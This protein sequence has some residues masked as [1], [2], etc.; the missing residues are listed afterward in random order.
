MG[1]QGAVVSRLD[2]ATHGHVA[3]GQRQAPA[4]S[5][6]GRLGEGAPAVDPGPGQRSF[7]SDGVI[8]RGHVVA[9]DCQLLIVGA[10]ERLD[11]V[12]GGQKIGVGQRPDAA[13]GAALGLD[14][15]LAGVG[16]ERLRARAVRDLAQLDGQE[17]IDNARASG[18]AQDKQ[19]L[20]ILGVGGAG[21][22]RGAQGGAGRG[23]GR[24]QASKTAQGVSTGDGR[25]V[26]RNSPRSR[27]TRWSSRR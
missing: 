11:R 16:I 14:Q 5:L 27:E 17:T 1:H 18:R 9:D 3:V 8:D 23:Q 25:M 19:E 10:Q 7:L 22:I 24:A 13:N 6:G 26:H 2:I 20:A 15:E 21:G 12:L 4:V